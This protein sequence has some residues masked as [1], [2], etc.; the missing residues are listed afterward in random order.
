MIRVDVHSK[1]LSISTPM[2]YS[3]TVQDEIEN[4][5]EA[6]M[7][8]ACNSILCSQSANGSSQQNLAFIGTIVTTTERISLLA[9]G[10][11][12]VP[13][14]IGVRLRTLY[15]TS[16]TSPLTAIP[17]GPVAAPC[18]IPCSSRL[19]VFCFCPALPATRA[20]GSHWPS[21]C[22]IELSNSFWAGQ[23]LGTRPAIQG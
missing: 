3:W 1:G 9:V 19:S 14:G 7:Q 16:A 18:T 13:C 5:E 11:A 4:T 2:G 20:S 15:D 10:A 17:K 6:C 21:C 12:P 23:A 8:V 22:D